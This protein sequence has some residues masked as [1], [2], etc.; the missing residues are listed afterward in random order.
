MYSKT[1]LDPRAWVGVNLGRCSTTPNA[2][3]IWCPSIGRVVI[4]SDAYFMEHLYPQRPKG[5]Q[6]D[7]EV[8]A[9]PEAGA[10]SGWGESVG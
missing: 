10:S 9:V 8:S 6:V 5:L 1:T 4:T 2:F 7:D 3:K